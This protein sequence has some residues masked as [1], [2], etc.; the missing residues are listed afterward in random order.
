M[1][2]C[3]IPKANRD[4]RRYALWK[5]L[6]YILGYTAYIAFM[7]A[8]FWFFLEGRHENL[9]PLRWWVYPVF[10]GAVLVSGWFIFCMSRF[11]SDRSF[12]GRI[13]SMTFKRDFDRGLNRQAGFS[14]DDHTYVKFTV[15]DEKGR[16]HRTKVM[17]FDDGYDG[18]FREGRTLIKYR[19]LNYPLC[20]QAEEEGVHLC[21]VCGVRTYYKEGRMKDGEMRPEMLGDLIVCRSCGHTLMGEK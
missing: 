2:K 5:N 21:S 6:K 9:G 1:H 8:A 20:P 16:R 12:K 14:V 13:V 11:V 18:Y 17:L 15:V 4:L 19:G 3:K 10:V 7:A